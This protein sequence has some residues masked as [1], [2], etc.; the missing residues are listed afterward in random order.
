MIMNRFLVSCAVV[1]LS[2][3]AKT[4]Y[5]VEP[6][7]VQHQLESICSVVL[8]VSGTYC[9]NKAWGDP[10]KKQR[11]IDFARMPIEDWC[12][13]SEDWWMWEWYQQDDI[14]FQPSYSTATPTPDSYDNIQTNSISS[15]VPSFSSTPQPLGENAEEE[16]TDPLWDSSEVE[17]GNICNEIIEPIANSVNV[18]LVGFK[19]RQLVDLSRR[20]T[21]FIIPAVGDSQR[22]SDPYNWVMTNAMAHKSGSFYWLTLP[23]S[24]SSNDDSFNV[25]KGTTKYF[26]IRV[27]VPGENINPPLPNRTPVPGASTIVFPD[28]SP[29]KMNGIYR[30]YFGEWLLVSLVGGETKKVRYDGQ[31]HEYILTPQFTDVDGRYTKI[32]EEL[33]RPPPNFWSSTADI[34]L[35][36][37]EEPQQDGCERCK[38]STKVYQTISGKILSQTIAP[39]S[40]EDTSF[41]SA[42]PAAP[43][44]TSIEDP[45]RSD[46]YSCQA[47]PYKILI[48]TDEHT[49]NFGLEAAKL[50]RNVGPFNRLSDKQIR[51]I[52]DTSATKSDIGCIDEIRSDGTMNCS[53]IN[54]THYVS[55]IKRAVSP[56]LTLVLPGLPDPKS[57]AE[58]YMGEQVI[59]QPINRLA[60]LTS[61]YLKESFVQTFVHEAGHA[62]GK[63]ADEYDYVVNNKDADLRCAIPVQAPN[64]ISKPLRLTKNN[65]FILEL[66]SLFN[67]ENSEELATILKYLLFH[68][69]SIDLSLTCADSLVRLQNALSQ[70][71]IYERFDEIMKRSLSRFLTKKA[72]YI[73]HIPVTGP[74]NRF[75][76]AIVCLRKTEPVLKGHFIPGYYEARRCPGLMIEAKPFFSETFMGDPSAIVPTLYL[77]YMYQRIQSELGN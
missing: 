67:L 53:T 3:Q 61:A 73:H 29:T 14:N 46:S 23:F 71:A 74:D 52:I 24:T 63:F 2:M 48:I 55:R 41:S 1:A 9:F 8:G 25:P 26:W 22:W 42:Y 7:C 37:P 30:D 19:P 58:T 54:S 10:L 15:S 43:E 60:D 35:A 49:R 28:Y 34:P 70:C 32:R 18:Q 16:L 65:L 56:N 27:N 68:E 72:P 69:K 75:I 76:D 50:I 33:K 20:F 6:N 31:Y 4:S 44:S 62:V 11:M 77:D 64:L 45:D 57:R 36:E 5:A 38:N 51:F 47:E 39:S 40:H 12:R 21:V 59:V 13:G 66:C 17:E